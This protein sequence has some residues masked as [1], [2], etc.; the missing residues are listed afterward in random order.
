MRVTR[1]EQPTRDEA[2]FCRPAIDAANWNLRHDRGV[3]VTWR[4][5]LNRPQFMAREANGNTFI[6]PY[7][8]WTM[9]PAFIHEGKF[10]AVRVA[11]WS[12]PIPVAWIIHAAGDWASEDDR[13][14]S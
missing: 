11:G 5:D 14:E 6:L 12:R 1:R 7:R 2:R 9:G 13:V 3:H 8:G 4:D 10:A